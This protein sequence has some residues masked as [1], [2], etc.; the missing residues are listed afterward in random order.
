[1]PG[2]GCQRIVLPA[3][4]RNFESVCQPTSGPAPKPGV[5][6]AHPKELS[7]IT[8]KALKEALGSNQRVWSY[9]VSSFHGKKEPVLVAFSRDYLLDVVHRTVGA[10]AGF[11][12]MGNLTNW[13]KTSLEG[14]IETVLSQHKARSGYAT[15]AGV[16]RPVWV[17][18]QNQIKLEQGKTLRSEQVEVLERI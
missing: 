2:V 11:Q 18:G 4:V 17:L 6:Q 12:Q 14:E 13:L 5:Y 7:D 16:N 3:R 1:M 9:R 15:L 8:V 10:H